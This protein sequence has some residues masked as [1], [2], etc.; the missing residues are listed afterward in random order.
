MLDLS[1]E[2]KALCFEDSTPKPLYVFLYYWQG[3]STHENGGYWKY[4]TTIDEAIVLESMEIDEGVL[5]G[6]SFQL[7]SFVT[8]SV[9]VQWQNNGISYKDKIGRASCRERV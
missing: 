6:N 4:F 3:D 8:H 1:T 9:K 5:E 2:N 7:G